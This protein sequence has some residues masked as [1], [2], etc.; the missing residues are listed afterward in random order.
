MNALALVAILGQAVCGQPAGGGEKPAAEVRWVDLVSL[1]LD[2]LIDR[3]PQVGSEGKYS[4]EAKGWVY[5]GA[6]D[7][8]KRR[9]DSGLVVKGEQWQKALLRAG[10]FRMRERWP[11]GEPVVVAMQDSRWLERCEIT[12]RPRDAGLRELKGGSTLMETCGNALEWRAREQM[13]QKLGTL[14]LGK[15]HVV[16]DASIVRGRHWFGDDKAPEGLVWKGELAFDVEIVPTLEEAVPVVETKEMAAAVREALGVCSKE[17]GKDKKPV[18]ILVFDA[19][20]RAHPELGTTA[21][22]MDVELVRDGEVKG[23]TRVLVHRYDSTMGMNS[24]YDGPVKLFSFAL[25]EAVPGDMSGEEAGHW[26]LRC[27]SRSGDVLKLWH[28]DTQWKGSFEVGLGEVLE[29]ETSR[30]KEKGERMF[31]WMP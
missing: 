23:K 2:E 31:V 20:T 17:W 22:D 28:A 24:V 7:E 9:V 19:D 12:L 30:M 18:S 8:M 5:N 25:L 4:E 14:P 6:V 21:I 3:L 27:T 16:F 10:V 13:Q 26:K 1:S 11:V 15:Q 29:R